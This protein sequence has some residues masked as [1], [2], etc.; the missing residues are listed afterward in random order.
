M[1]SGVGSLI[2]EAVL[3]VPAANKERAVHVVLATAAVS[4]GRPAQVGHPIGP[5]APTAPVRIGNH[6]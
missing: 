6:Q 3:G 2:V 5:I 4:S 1:H